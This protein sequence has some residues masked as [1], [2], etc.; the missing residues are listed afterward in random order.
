MVVVQMELIRTLVHVIQV[1]VEQGAPKV[2]TSFMHLFVW[3]TIKCINTNI[4]DIND[5]EPDPCMHGSCIDGINLYACMCDPG[6]SGTNC[7]EGII[8]KVNF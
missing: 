5:C 2:Q 1:I 4:I 8:K 7:S 6:Y 3:A